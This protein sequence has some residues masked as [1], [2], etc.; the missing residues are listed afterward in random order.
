MKRTLLAL[1]LITTLCFNFA[2]ERRGSGT[3]AVDGGGE[4]VIGYYGDLTG[5]TASFGVSTKNGVEMAA[6]EINKAGGVMGRKIRVIV[7]DDQGE[8]NK[9]ATVVSKLVNQD[10][11]AAVLGEVAS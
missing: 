3:N 7:E 4:I 5:R 2:C 8:P 10:K 6:D 11:V 1:L 9:A